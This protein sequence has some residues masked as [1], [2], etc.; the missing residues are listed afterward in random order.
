[1]SSFWSSEDSK[2]INK[3]THRWVYFIP[4]DKA[5]LMKLSVHN[6]GHLKRNVCM[7][8]WQWILRFIWVLFKKEWNYFKIYLLISV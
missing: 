4:R 6:T 8:D 3:L 7:Y 5:L 1:M 2:L